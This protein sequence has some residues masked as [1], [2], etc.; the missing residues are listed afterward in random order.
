M[1][2]LGCSASKAARHFH[3]SE[4]SAR[5]WV[6]NYR[7]SG[8]FGR[9]AGSGI[10]KISTP[11]QYARSVA[12]VEMNPFHTAATLKAVF[13]FPGH[14]QTVRNRLRDTNLRSRR[15]IPREVHKEENIEEHLIF[16]VGND[17]WD[18][19]K[20]IFSDEVTS[21]TTKE[22]PIF[23]YRP[24]G[25]RFVHIPPFV[26]EVVEYLCRVGGGFLV[27]ESAQSIAFAG[28]STSRNSNGCWNAIW[29]FMLGYHILMESFN[30]SRI[31]IQSTHLN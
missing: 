22:G 14:E 12:E 17:D 1:V 18:W 20:V 25:T 9:K 6:H 23:V 5:R 27:V 13:N 30:F 16:A 8:N 28:N 4:R 7:R 15:A 19:K 31:I 24:P 10:W 3:V 21:S 29:C 26:P 11:E 2:Q